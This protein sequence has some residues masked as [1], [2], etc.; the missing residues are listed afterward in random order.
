MTGRAW[1]FGENIDTDALAPGKYMRLP[2]AELAQHCLEGVDPDFAPNVKPG[3]VVVG[4]RNFGLGSSREQAAEALKILGVAA[5][6]APSFAGIFYRNAFNLGLPALICPDAGRITAGDRV[7]LDLEAGVLRNETQGTT[8]AFRPLPD[9]LLNL[10]RRGGLLA[11]L[12][13]T[14]MEKSA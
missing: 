8:M 13:M 7:T 3:D 11:H 9:V 10:V 1:T 5:V 12:Q 14:R 4:G 2:V 6:I